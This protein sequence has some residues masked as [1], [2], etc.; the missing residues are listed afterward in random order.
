MAGRKL[1][2]AVDEGSLP[3]GVAEGEVLDHARRIE[4]RRQV[5]M[6]EQGAQLAGH[7]QEAVEPSTSRA[8]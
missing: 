1:A 3:D 8:A 6:S 2:H 7:D 4:L 5:W